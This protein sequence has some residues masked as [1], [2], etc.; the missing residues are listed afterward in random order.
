MLTHTP[1]TVVDHHP[2]FPCQDDISDFILLDDGAVGLGNIGEGAAAGAV[3][4]TSVGSVVPVVGNVIGGAVGTIVGGITG[5]IFGNKKNKDPLGGFTPEEYNALVTVGGFGP[6]VKRKNKSA[7]RWLAEN[8]YAPSGD[9]VDFLFGDT[10][11]LQASGFDNNLLLI[12]LGS[13]VV[14]AMIFLSKTQKPNQKE[15]IIQDA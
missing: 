10:L 4:G 13:G 2:G 12:A 7:Q 5:G 15:I 11:D 8:F 9:A 14:G 6:N 1:L 3:F